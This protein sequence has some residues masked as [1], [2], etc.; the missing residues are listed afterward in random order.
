MRID[1]AEPS[2][3]RRVPVPKYIPLRLDGTISARPL[4]RTLTVGRRFS[5]SACVPERHSHKV[6]QILF[7]RYSP[8]VPTRLPL[9]GT[10]REPLRLV[11]DG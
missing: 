6:R 10:A 4:F 1:V 11:D 5:V 7:L 8:I 2:Y 3:A 9:K